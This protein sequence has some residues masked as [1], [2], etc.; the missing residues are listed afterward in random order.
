MKMGV[1]VRESQ[2]NV[3]SVTRLGDILDFGQ[4]Y[5]GFGN[6]YIAPIF[7]ILSRFL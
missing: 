3:S 6:N 4:L 1:C 7:P 5:E 2:L